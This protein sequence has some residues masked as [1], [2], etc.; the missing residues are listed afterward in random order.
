MS[1]KFRAL[2]VVASTLICFDFP[3]SLWYHRRAGSVLQLK[4]ANT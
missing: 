2:M 1:R 4:G 3:R